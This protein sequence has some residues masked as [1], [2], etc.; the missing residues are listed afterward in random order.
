MSK[1]LEQA[2]FR[3]RLL[4]SGIN[5]VGLGFRFGLT[6]KLWAS[7]FGPAHQNPKT[8]NLGAATKLPRTGRNTAQNPLISV[9]AA[10]QSQRC[11][12]PRYRAVG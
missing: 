6:E 10:E 11:G 8:E 9:G 7:V 5:V 1:H 4:H 3:F 2:C 12:S